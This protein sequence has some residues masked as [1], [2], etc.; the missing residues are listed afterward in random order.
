MSLRPTP[1]FWF[2]LVVPNADADDAMEALARRGGIQFEWVGEQGSTGHLAP[3]IALSQRWQQ[4]ASELSAYWPPPVFEKRCCTLPLEK[5]ARASLRQLDGWRREAAPLLTQRDALGQRLDE[6]RAWEPLLCALNA[7]GLELDSLAR[8]GPALAARGVV[9]PAQFDPSST[10]VALC[11]PLPRGEEGAA[12]LCLIPTGLADDLCQ[13]AAA[14]G[15]R[16]L[17]LPAWLVSSPP[18]KWAGELAARA[19]AA[20]LEAEQLDS[21]LRALAERRGIGQAAGVMERI[22]WFLATAGQIRC[23]NN[24]C[25]I[26]GWSAEA[27]GE[28]IDRELHELGIDTSIQFLPAPPDAPMPSLTHHP[29]WTRPFEVFADAIGVPGTREADPTT[30]VALLVPLMFGYMCGD[31]GHGGLIVL[32]GVLLRRSTRLWPLLIFCGAASAAFGWVYGD[33]FGFGGIVPALWMHPL[34]DPLRVLLVPMVA[35]ALVMTLGVVLHTMQTCWR[36]EGGSEGVADA[37]QLLV[38]WGV[39][40]LLVDT[41]FGWLGVGGLLLCIGNRLWCAPT[42]LALLAGLGHLLESTLQ[43]LVNTVSFARVGAFALAHAALESAIVGVAEDLASL[44]VAVGVVVIGNLLVVALEGMVVSIQASRL[45]LFE[46]FLR[47]F[48]GQGRR[49][50]PA[51]RP[52]T[53]GDARR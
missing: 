31:V 34:D 51:A 42:P 41:R 19:A 13:R 44:P 50:D 2:E 46:F 21:A 40:L 15:G 35:G 26:S 23:D 38:Y 10:G 27:N 14:S 53:D 29:A 12:M 8:T 11:R 18:A 25:R 36:G 37:A 47:F 39:L 7:T 52:P 32:T 28:A 9:L 3:L 30:W 45:V 1:A 48:E 5:A 43:M 6:L 16:C 4:L 33:L 20:E 49:F 22:D 24:M 17:R